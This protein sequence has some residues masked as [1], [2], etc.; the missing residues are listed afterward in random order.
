[1]GKKSASSSTVGGATSGKERASGW[2]RSKFTS[3]DLRKLRKYGLLPTKTEA[4]IPDDE[5]MPQPEEGWRAFIFH[6]TKRV[7]H[8]VGGTI[9]CVRPEADYFDYKMVESVQNWCQKWFYIKDEKVGEQKFGLAPFDPM[10]EVKKLKSWD[11][12]LTGAEVK[13]TEPLVA[14]IHALQNNM[15]KELSGLQIMIHF[16]RLRVQPIQAR[17]SAMWAYARSKD[18]TRISE[19][20]L[21]TAELEKMARHF[22][23]LT[24]KDDIPSS[25]ADYSDHIFL[26]CLPPLPEGGEIS[27]VA[28]DTEGGV[29]EAAT[30]QDTAKADED[31]TFELSHT[32]T[33][34]P[35]ANS[36]D[37]EAKGKRKRSDD[38]EDSDSLSASKPRLVVPISSDAPASSFAPPNLFY[39]ALDLSSD[40]EETPKAPSR[41][42]TRILSAFI[43]APAKMVNPQEETVESPK[44]EEVAE[45]PQAP[46]NKKSKKDTANKGITI[47]E[48]PTVP[49]MD[50]MMD[51]AI[52]YIKFRDEA[53]ELSAAL[54]KSEK[55][56]KELEAKLKAAEEALGDAR[57][58]AKAE[59]E[60]LA[61]E[62]SQMATRE[63][64]IRLRLDALTASFIK[65]VGDLYEMPEDQ[66]TDP[67]LDSLTMLEANSVWVRNVLVHA[68]RAF[69]RLFGHFFP[70]KK[71]PEDLLDLANVFTAKEDPA[72][73]Y[74]RAATKTGVEIAMAM[75]MAHGE[76][77]NWEKPLVD[78]WVDPELASGPSLQESM[79]E[80]PNT[81]ETADQSSELSSGTGGTHRF[82][83]LQSELKIL[84]DQIVVALLKAKRAAEREDYLLILISRASDDLLC[85]QLNS[86]TEEER[87]KARM[88]ALMEISAETGSDF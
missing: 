50:D 36:Q 7:V 45:S 51:M 49:S 39:L 18:P 60:K 2:S 23:R 24:A 30:G 5:V 11:Q 40:E 1:M 3:G 78:D 32:A 65:K 42:E 59:E 83:E 69:K 86:V 81:F 19:E 47:S 62:K 28:A 73:N 80:G 58:K 63:A 35:P 27:E 29:P 79:P 4:K 22:T 37:D 34:I 20:N 84:K 41:D 57:A 64:D 48:N 74:R 72:L 52:R 31:A 25:S 33:S 76:N 56:A 14:R 46:P 61:E 66:K 68:R 75:S 6:P 77:V 54:K 44:S 8:D 15:G 71:E 26:S 10:K 13:E 70:R 43:K 55:H 67:L 17:A 12:P 53:S 87:V 9:I 88:N 21:S 82:E 85:A 38:D 16:L